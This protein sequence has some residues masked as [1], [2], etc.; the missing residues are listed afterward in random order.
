MA[1]KVKGQ[2][3]V[4]N[5]CARVETRKTRAHTHECLL[6]LAV[7]EADD[8]TLTTC[9]CGGGGRVRVWLL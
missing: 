3:A 8:V 1:V 6:S 2:V 4:V 9:C 5:V 7:D